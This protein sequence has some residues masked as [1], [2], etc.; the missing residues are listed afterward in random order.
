VGVARA[1]FLVGGD[2]R[3]ARAW[4]KASFLG[5]AM[6]VL[7]AARTAAGGPGAGRKG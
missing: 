2:G 5:H 3:I 4:P 7:A 1:T 6:E